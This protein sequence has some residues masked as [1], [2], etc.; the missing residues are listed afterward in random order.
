MQLPE[1]DGYNFVC[2]ADD[3]REPIRFAVLRND[4]FKHGELAMEHSVVPTKSVFAFHVTRPIWNIYVNCI[5]RLF[6]VNEMSF[7]LP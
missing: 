4:T 3:Y 1:G 5:E 7:T 2:T 6:F